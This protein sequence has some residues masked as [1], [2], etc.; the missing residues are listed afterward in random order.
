MNKTPAAST[1]GKT[2]SAIDP[3]LVIVDPHHHLWHPHNPDYLANV[4]QAD[5]LESGHRVKA[6]VYV[7]CTAMYRPGGPEHLRTVGEAEFVAGMA[8]M[9][10]SGT[11]GPTRICAGFVGAADLMLGD[12]VDEVLDALAMASGGRLRGL[13]GATIWDADTS[14][15]TGTR[16][17]APQGVMHDSR[18][19]AGVARMS[20]RNL[21]YDAWQYYPQL[22]DLCSL[23]DH[24]PNLK[25]VVNHCGGL[26]AIGPYATADNFSRWRHLIAETAKR[27]NVTMKLGG[28]AGGRTGFGYAKRSTRASVE[29]LVA[30]W[31]PYIESCIELFGADRCMFESNFAVDIIAGDYATIWNTFKTIAAKCSAAEK[32]A[33]F[34]GTAMKIYDVG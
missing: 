12:G 8:A 17:F 6:T 11:Y 21:V 13:R 16:P 26:L 10:D 20:A 9:G 3:E 34:S 19:R 28:L 31:R 2:A 30:D 33:L 27:P 24:F 15:N 7:E 23:A 18:F 22:A 5:I 1:S 32:Q 14:L 25:I 4:F 29:D